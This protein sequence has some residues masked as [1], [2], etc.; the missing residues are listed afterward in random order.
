VLP[1]QLCF[2]RHMFALLVHSA[3]PLCGFILFHHSILLQPLLCKF[4][5]FEW[6]PLLESSVA[7]VYIMQLSV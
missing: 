5:D 7:D 4:F 1:L 6:G 2:P 3:S